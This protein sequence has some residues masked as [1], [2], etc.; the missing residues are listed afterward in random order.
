MATQEIE[1]KFLVQGPGWKA[2]TRVVHIR[3]GF[4]AAERERTVRVRIAGDRAFLTV[5]SALKGIVRQEFEYQIPVA[6]ADQIL[7]LCL[8]PWIE[9]RRH[10]I[11]HQGMTWEVDEFLGEN[12]GLVLAEIE[13]ETEDQD[14]ARP[15]WLGQEVS[16]DPR[17]LNANLVKRPYKEW[18]KAQKGEG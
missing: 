13:L 3:Q 1:R 8:R 6:D 9:K 11:S 17:Y 15:D 16:R 18:G 5:K 7:K 12:E 10:L 14:F 2:A 4:L